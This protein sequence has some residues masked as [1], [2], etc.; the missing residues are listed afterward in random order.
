MVILDPSVKEKKKRAAY[1]NLRRA[2]PLA[3]VYLLSWSLE[4]FLI[5]IGQ[6]TVMSEVL[7]GTIENVQEVFVVFVNPQT[8]AFALLQR[9]VHAK[10]L[11]YLVNDIEGNGSICNDVIDFIV[12]DGVYHFF[13]VAEESYFTRDIAGVI[14]CSSDDCDNRSFSCDFRGCNN[15]FVCCHIKAGKGYFL[16]SCGS[17]RKSGCHEITAFVLESCYSLS[18]F[19][20]RPVDRYI[21]MKI[22]TELYGEVFGEFYIKSDEA[23]G[24]KIA[25]GWNVRAY[26]D[27]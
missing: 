11:G 19:N 10:F 21:F 20:D 16:S 26:A 14:S 22:D 23:P 3:M 9:F 24:S 2:K 15:D 6:A 25:E 7:Q 17:I 5:D 8:I 13:V 27:S 18:C 4:P 1:E 12:G